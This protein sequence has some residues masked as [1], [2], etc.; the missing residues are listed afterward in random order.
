MSLT[1]LLLM[2]AVL[3]GVI[4][5]LAL[6]A[7]AQAADEVVFD[8]PWVVDL[9]DDNFDNFVSNST[10]WMLELRHRASSFLCAL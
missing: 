2:R 7:C 9:N 10:S 8:S 5:L 6:A 3:C 1:H 4:A